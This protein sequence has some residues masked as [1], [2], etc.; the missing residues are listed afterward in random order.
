MM[1]MVR[2][3]A[4]ERGAA[5]AQEQAHSSPAAVNHPGDASYTLSLHFLVQTMEHESV[6]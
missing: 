2:L 1:Q 6:R 4:L 5:E 3:E